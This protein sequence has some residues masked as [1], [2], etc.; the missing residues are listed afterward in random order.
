VR[1]T[2]TVEI[3]RTGVR[4]TRLGLGGVALSAAP[5]SD[6]GARA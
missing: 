3:A 6:R 1:A 2:D 5:P 4:V